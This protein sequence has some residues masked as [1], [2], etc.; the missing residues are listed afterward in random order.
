MGQDCA[1]I[2]GVGGGDGELA[3]KLVGSPMTM[4]L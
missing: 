4:E 2:D 3:N 1:T